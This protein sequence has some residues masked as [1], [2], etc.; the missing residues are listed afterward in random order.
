MRQAK[1]VSA[2]NAFFRGASVTSPRLETTQKALEI[3]L[4]GSIYG[5]FAEVGAGQEV[6]RHFFRAGGGAGTIAKSMSAY[7]M[8]ISDD[9]YGKTERYVS[10]ERLR[11][12]LSRESDLLQS[13]L[14]KKSMK[15][16]LFFSYAN[17]VQ[18]KNSQGNGWMGIRFQRHEEGEFSQVVLHVNMFDRLSVQQ[19]EVVGVIG[20]NL[21]YACYYHLWERGEEFIRSLMD[22]LPPNRL[23][24]DMIQVTGEA[25]EGED[26]R[27]WSLELV[28]QNLCYSVMFNP[29]GNVLLA[30]DCLY[31]K[32]I[33]IC[34]GGYR[35]PNKLSRDMMEKAEA[36]FKKQLISGERD[37]LLVLPEISMNT[38]LER[39]KVDNKDF[40]ARV[41]LLGEL[42]Y[43]TLISNY[44][45]YARLSRYL[46]TISKKEA[47][48]VLN[49]YSLEEM[50]DEKNYRDYPGGLLGG[51]AETLGSRTRLY[52]YPAWDEVKGV[53]LTGERV[54][55]KGEAGH[56]VK[57]LKLKK[58]M[59]FLN[60]ADADC[61]KIW[62]RELLKMIQIGSDGWEEMVPEV[63]RER[64]KRDRLFGHPGGG[65]P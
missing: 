44:Q 61:V 29:E 23:E 51:M 35:P 52:C 3:N 36:A 20:V 22:N 50:L 4:N 26:S 5:T 25:F 17:T 13:R 53:F 63:V 27:L 34:R 47:A 39:G 18:T 15:K 54:E 12:M 58:R 32:N 6:V 60:D 45:N 9:I 7:D 19:Q 28:K 48:I 55:S 1:L 57:Y 46:S 42:G 49:Y 64:V 30:K 11:T 16:R 33:L 43:H 21:I 31:T 10:L 24:I 41:N 8:N 62:S 65:S 38:L 37:N 56:L 14:N 40:L 2:G 59:N